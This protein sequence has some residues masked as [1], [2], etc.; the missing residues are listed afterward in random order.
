[1]PLPLILPFGFFPNQKGRASGVLIP[2]YGEEKNRGFFFRSGGYYF[3]LSEYADLAIRGDIYTNGT[4]G[5]RLSSRYKKRYKFTG[6]LNARYYK[7]VSG[8]K[9][10]STYRTS[11]D[12]SIA[13][14]H[15]QD[16]K[17]NPGSSFS[18]NVN[19]SSS[20]FDQK[21]SRTSNSYLTNTKTSSISYSRRWEGTPF[22]F[23]ASMNHSQNS[24]NK[25]VSLNLPRA[26]FNM[27]RIYP[28]KPKN[29]VG[30]TK[31]YQNIELR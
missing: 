8:E 4:Y 20:S 17:N 19:M 22:N 1:L 10:L 12:Y 24:R 29:Q 2:D 6:N 16:P 21:Y 7:S 23:S 3:A 28:F 30:E 26:N 27:S 11:N 9:G 13:W 25:T 15:S 5:L 18:G 14:S 31:W